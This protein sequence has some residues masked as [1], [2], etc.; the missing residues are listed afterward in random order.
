[1]EHKVFKIAGMS[2]GHCVAAIED[3]V[4]RLDGIESVYAS[5]EEKT[6]VVD[7]DNN[8]TSEAVIKKTIEDQ[9]FDVID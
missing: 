1:M 7:F 9:G 5:L 3:N 8:K 2:C 6:A 4:S